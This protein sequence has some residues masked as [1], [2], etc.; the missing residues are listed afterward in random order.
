LKRFS[1]VQARLPPRSIF[2]VIA[3]AIAPVGNCLHHPTMARVEEL[4][5]SAPRPLLAH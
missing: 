3:A 4:V 2:D 5:Q 1:N